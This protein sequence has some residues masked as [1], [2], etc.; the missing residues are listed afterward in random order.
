MMRTWLALAVVCSSLVARAD[1]LH[2]TREQPLFEVSHTV[3]VRISNGVATY[4]VRRQFANPGKI[5]DEAGLAIDLP[6]GAAATGMRI[7]AHEV[8]YDAELMEREKAAA[9]YHE[10]T[11]L[12]AYAPKDPALL[13]WMWAD[14]LYLQVFPVMPGQVSTVEYT[15]TVPTR[16]MSGRY[17]LSYPRVDASASAGATDRDGKTLKLAT[18]IITIHPSWGDAQTPITIDGQ[19]VAADT[20]VVLVPPVRE[21]WADAVGADGTASYVASA[22]EVPASSHTQKLLKTVKLELDI[23]HTYKSD[24]RVDLLTPQGKRVAIFEGSGGGT[25]DIKGTFTP[26]LPEGTTGAGTWRLVVSDHAALDTGTLDAWSLT[27]G[28]SK[29][30]TN[31]AATDTPVF[32]PDAPESASDAGVASIAISPQRIDMWT[33]RLGRVVASDAHAFARLDV[34]VAPEVRAAP[35]HAQVVF[36]ID[37]SFSIGEAG[38]AAEL[39]ML[40]AYLTHVP[41]AEVELVTYRRLGKRVFGTFVAAKGFEQALASAKQRGALALGNGSALDDGAKVAAIALADRKGPRRVVLT[42]DQLLRTSLSDVAALAS[43]AKLSRETV[44]HVVVPHVDH[45][46]RASLE[47]ND[48]DRLTPLASTHHGIFA[49]LRGMPTHTIKDLVPIVLEL[50]RPTRIDNLA[51]AGLK[52]EE[53]LLHEGEGLR[54]MVAGKTAPTHVVMTGKLWSDPVRREV[55]VSDAFSIQ[56]AAFVFGADM[57]DSLSKDEQM[58]VA[59]MGRAVSPVTSYVAF[60]P[61]TRPSTIGLAETGTGSGYGAGGGMLGG[62]ANMEMRTPFDFRRL[63][64]VDKCIRSIKPAIGWSVRLAVETT[65]DEVV[66][67]GVLSGAG[68]MGTCLAEAVWSLRLDAHIFNE[69]RESFDITFAAP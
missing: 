34:E 4:K 67:V 59:I 25:N 17:W 62:S 63:V 39:D 9:L 18:P 65:K 12:G 36:V 42:T 3:D 20:P 38:L 33:A 14:K 44:V 29:D 28:E 51:V 49:E 30:T 23:K 37:A 21:A 58:R 6:Y 22:I 68:P 13:Q 32:V 8:W 7:R 2:A 47:R 16:Y 41:D 31:I 52:V 27:L 40:R 53:T 35:K 54:I 1:V 43:L 60:E 66:D 26:A 61:G 5:A 45:D 55:A 46:D 64:D 19:R 15:L 57:H 56:T 69:D 50:V 48:N 11:G 24:L 10:L